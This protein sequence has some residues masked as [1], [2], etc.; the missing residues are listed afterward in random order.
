M[1][2]RG[3]QP[4]Q[5]RDLT[6]ALPS[7]NFC[8]DD[9]ARFTSKFAQ[10]FLPVDRLVA[11]NR[12]GRRVLEPVPAVSCDLLFAMPSPRL[13]A[14]LIHGTSPNCNV[15]P[16]SSVDR[17]VVQPRQLDERFLHRIIGPLA[18]LQ[19]VKT[20]R[21]SVSVDQWLELR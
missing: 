16:R 10:M 9:L 1:N 18:P 6:E 7:P 8:H 12:I 17:R 5:I 21:S 11:L 15:Q 14:V 19:R 4:D 2:G 13:G 3:R 20:Q